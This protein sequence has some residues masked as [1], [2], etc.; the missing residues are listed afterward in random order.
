M[1]ATP[2]ITRREVLYFDHAGYPLDGPEG[3]TEIIIKEYDKDGNV[4]NTTYGSP[5]KPRQ[6]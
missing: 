2:K 4:V 6:E 1:D 3:A 5:G